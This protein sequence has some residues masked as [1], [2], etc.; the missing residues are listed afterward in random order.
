METILI[1]ATLVGLALPL[2]WY[3]A[4]ALGDRPSAVDRIF[5]P[6]ER[7]LF[8]VMRVESAQGMTWRGYAFAL[9]GTHL[10]IGLSA[11]LILF[12]QGA[13]PVNPDNISGM[14]WDLAVHTASSFITNTNQ[15]HYSGQ[16]QLSYFAHIVAIVSLQ[17]ITPAAGIAALL[18]VLRGLFGGRDSKTADAGQERD[19]G[20]FFVDTTRIIVRV[21][22]PLATIW[23]FVLVSQGV[24][25]TLEGAAE[26]TMLDPAVVSSGAAAQEIPRGPVA[27]MV[28][29][30]QLATN[31]G[32]WYGPNSSVPLENPTPVS[33]FFELV[34]IIL[35]P[36]ALVFMAGF[37]TRRRRFA[38][39]VFSVMAVISLAL[40]GLAIH[41]EA[42]PNA[43]FEGLAAVGPNMEGKEVRFGSETSALW[44]TFT[45]QTSNGSVNAMHDSLNPQAGFVTLLG[46]FV[47]ATWGGVGVGLI[48]F[49][50]FL[51]LT[52]F[53]AGLMVGRTPELF[54][55]KIEAREIK[56]AS[57]ALLLQP[58][59]ILVP[60]AIALSVGDL[61][62][63]SNPSFHGISQALYEYT[64]AFANNGSGFEGL[65]DDTV[66]WNIS[67]AVN[68]ILGRF[69]PIIAPLAIAGSLASKRRAPKTSGTLQIGTPTFAGMILSIILILQLLSFLPILVLGPIA[70]Q[71]VDVPE[72]ASVSTDSGAQSA[73]SLAPDSS[74][75][76]DLEEK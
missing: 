61:A 23:A 73:P 49:L 50:L 40:A 58:L 16:A 26:V 28:A 75:A 70:E 10:V 15:Q 66:W 39:M 56:L 51:I 57:I 64:S 48:N 31:G 35:I 47:N 8:R 42:A 54:G 33:N 36:M 76:S 55:K 60:S 32:G 59:L 2:G 27:P 7:L 74:N 1:Y 24:P 17:F 46:M 65:G 71:L 53:V 22:L 72:V 43:A 18:A 9:L 21:L 20:N 19:L 12:F 5:G 67:C 6:L 44:A 45:T 3:M 13:L 68:L 34:A 25:S 52:V 69:I 29:I 38:L 63:N 41:S 62:Q 4:L 14:S 37:W 30:K 11:F